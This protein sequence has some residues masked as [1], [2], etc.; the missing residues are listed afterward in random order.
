MNYW[1]SSGP[2][3]NSRGIQMTSQDKFKDG[4]CIPLSIRKLQRQAMHPRYRKESRVNLLQGFPHNLLLSEHLF[5]RRS[6]KIREGSVPLSLYSSGYIIFGIGVTLY[7]AS[8]LSQ[9][10]RATAFTVSVAVAHCLFSLLHPA[11]A[12]HLLPLPRSL[13]IATTSNNNVPS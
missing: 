9:V 3:I 5:D 2:E 13:Q 6:L 7:I 11:A 4:S 1:A 8:H 10:S 12:I